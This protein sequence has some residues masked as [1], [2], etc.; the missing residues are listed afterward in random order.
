MAWRVTA[1][2]VGGIF[3]KIGG[4]TMFLR[5]PLVGVDFER[6]IVRFVTSVALNALHEL[7]AP[8]Q[9]I[10]TSR[11]HHVIVLFER[12]VKLIADCA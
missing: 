9:L 5:V 10:F 7:W 12:N 4:E 11:Y 2:F 3:L 6:G 1:C 8:S